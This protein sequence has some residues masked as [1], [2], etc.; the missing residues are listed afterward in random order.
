M[1]YCYYWEKWNREQGP[2]ILETQEAF[3]DKVTP[4]IDSFSDEPVAPAD[5]QVVKKNFYKWMIQMTNRYKWFQ[6]DFNVKPI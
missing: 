6:T 3:S 5:V 4:D 1:K 2:G